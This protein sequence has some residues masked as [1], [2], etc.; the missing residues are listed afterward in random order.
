MTEILLFL[1]LKDFI[2]TC[3][4][5]RLKFCGSKCHLEFYNAARYLD[6]GGQAAVCGYGL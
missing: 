1:W 5:M 4:I 3:H 2:P 6:D